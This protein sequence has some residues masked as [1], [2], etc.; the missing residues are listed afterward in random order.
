M[1]RQ[2]I[3]LICILI[4][5][6]TS[7]AQIPI[8]HWREHLNY[9]NTIQVVKGNELYCATNTNLFSID[10]KGEITRYSKTNGLNDIGVNAIGWDE[11]TKQLIIA[12]KN[13]N[14]DI[15]KGSLVRNISDILQSKVAGNKT[16]NHI[17]CN[18]GIAYLSTGLGIIVVDLNRYEIKDSWIIGNNGSLSTINA[19]IADNSFFYA[20]SI[21]GLRRAIVNSTNLANFTNWSTLSGTN[22]LPLGSVDYVGIINNQLIATIKD[23]VYIFNNNSWRILYSD[24]SWKIINTN[25]SSDKLHICQK[26][27][28]GDARV[29][30]LSSLGTILS[31]LNKPGVISLPQSAITVNNATWVADQFGGLSKFTNDVERFIP[32]GPA[33][34]ASGEFAFSKTALFAAAGSVNR[35]W[36]YLYNRDGIFKFGEGN[37]SSKGALNT[38]QLDTTLDFITIAVD[39][40]KQSLWA[41]SYG[42][43]LVQITESRTTIYKQN[44]SLLEAAIGD[45]TSFRVSG[46]AFDIS[47]NLWISN[48]GAP[49]PLKLLKTD[50]TWKSF[51]IPFNLVENAVAQIINDDFNQLWIVSPKNNGLICYQYGN[52]VDNTSDD[53]W[54]LLKQGIGNGNLPSNNILSIVKDKN[55]SIWV[56]T[57]DGIAVLNCNNNIFGSGGCDA[58]LPIVQQDQF[59]GFLFKGEQVQCIAVDGANK[60]WVGTLN[61]VWLISSDGKKLIQH[62]TTA[63]SP[64]LSN[65]VKKIGIDPQSGEVFFATFNGIC[66]Y[67]STATEANESFNNVLVFPNPVP[68]GYNGT[69]AIKGLTDNSIVKITELNGRL[70]YQTRSLGGQ[71]I[72]NGKDY[73]GN[74]IA[75]GVYLVV[76]RNDSREEKIVTKIIITSG[77]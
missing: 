50:G 27:N 48:Y 43:G 24:S 30:I 56:G 36:N 13:S 75:S 72:W 69:I 28:T 62:F 34:I 7:V 52:N 15:L 76:A 31:T 32:N 21:D 39:P 55:N 14:L 66:S 45:P 26:N 53:Q 5:I 57:D 60:K 46:L 59:A 49:Q 77:R 68:S 41:G 40:I 58:I 10:D 73:N 44:N 33:G 42:G 20:A 65:D 67:R 6:N 38:S 17:Y 64:L 23:T 63:N 54:K 18:N 47:N 4:C 1:F 37:W 2:F 74:K 16:I 12:Y 22:G 29:I 51:S 11:T 8:G 70:V 9:Q 35:A 61:G 3:T 25:I 71:A 19:T